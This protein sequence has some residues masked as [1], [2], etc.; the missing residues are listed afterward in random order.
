[1]TTNNRKYGLGRGLDAILSSPDTDITSTDISG[2]YV[3][4]A[5][6][7]IN[8]DFIEANP[9]QPR[10]DFDEEA[11]NELAESIKSQG[12]IQPVTVRKMGRG[13]YQLISGERRLR[14]ARIA[15]L[16]TIPV[17]IRVAD[18]E[19]M[20]ELALIENTHRESLNAIEVAIS[21]QRLIDECKLSID[22]LSEKVGKD[23]TTVTNFLRLLKLPPEVQIAIR[24][25]LITMGH[26]RAII[27][28]DDRE[29]QLTLL[30]EIIDKELTVRQVENLSRSVRQPV[31]KEKKA[32]GKTN[33]ISDDLRNSIEKFIKST[34]LKT[35]LTRDIKG[36]GSITISFKN[37]DDLKRIID[38]IEKV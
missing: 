19:Q 27:N 32:Q 14:A 17:F 31:K 2:N 13:K 6:A 8:I 29:Q 7:E 33:V 35:K 1:M 3:A 24:D 16:K 21:Y 34:A 9:F 10:N 23:R 38:I 30:K 5:V 15:G 20:L 25:R 37:D 26:A 36:K 28:I 11:I 22:S 18:D 12:I 4:G